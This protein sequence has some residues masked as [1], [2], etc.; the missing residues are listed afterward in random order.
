MADLFHKQAK[1]YVET[2]PSYPEELFEFIASKTPNH[3]LVWDVGTG[4]GQ[5]AKSLAKLYKNVVGTDTSQEQL[6]YAPKLPNVRYQCTPPNIPL[7]ELESS[8]APPG[9]VDLVTVAQALHWFDLPTFYQQVK[10]VLKKPHG[11]IAAWCYTVPEAR[12]NI[13][14]VNDKFDAVFRQ[15]YADSQ[16]YWDTARKLV[17]GKYKGIDFPFEPV[18]DGAN[19]TGPFEFTTVRVMDLEGFLTYIRSWSAY[20]T[21]K[22]KGVELLSEDAVESFKRAWGEDGVDQKVVKAPVYLRI[23]KVGNSE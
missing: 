11:V 10:L 15:F 23:G 16:P 7:S 22:D 13:P 19:H 1:N 12:D 5:A 18:G 9:T 14:V 20:Q 2:R 3:D 4:S 17:D 6:D 21:A 8:V